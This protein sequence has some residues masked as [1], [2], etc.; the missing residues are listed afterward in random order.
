[1]YR[2]TH[3]N[4][5]VK[6]DVSLS[7]HVVARL[8]VG[9]IVV[10]L[11][12]VNVPE[13]HRVRARI[14]DPEGW[15]TLRE[16]R[17]NYYWASLIRSISLAKAKLISDIVDRDRQL[18]G[19]QGR[20]LRLRA[21]H[22]THLNNFRDRVEEL[23]ARLLDTKLMPV[24]EASRPRARPA[25]PTYMHLE[26]DRALYKGLPSVPANTPYKLVDA[27]QVPLDH[28]MRRAL[29]WYP[30]PPPPPPSQ[31]PKDHSHRAG[32]VVTS[33]AAFMPSVNYPGERPA[34]VYPMTWPRGVNLDGELINQIYTPFPAPDHY[35]HDH[36]GAWRYTE[37]GGFP[38]V[39]GRV[40]MVADV[41]CRGD[42][43]L[44][45]SVNYVAARQY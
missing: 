9:Q 23:E 25:A 3:N 18:E 8:D 38:F 17:T 30:P 13:E 16:T 26:G 42:H 31:S 4:A 40:E 12:L 29:A 24:A 6:S 41:Y 1:V 32:N 44:H 22:Q 10:V 11:E 2:V 34:G 33:N 21:E 39:A 36:P 45:P 37:A 28:E 43:R 14:A 20:C 7:A 27:Q 19:L 15:M 35:N 5:A